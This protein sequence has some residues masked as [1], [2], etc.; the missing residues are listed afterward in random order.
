MEQNTALQPVETQHGREIVNIEDYAMSIDGLVGQVSLIQQVM[1]KVMKKDE[2]Y[3]VIPGTG[4]K[5]SLL[6]PGAEKLCLTFRL[7]P[8]YEIIREVR[9]RDFIAYTVKCTLTHIPT[10]Q[11]IA[12][13]IG[14][15]NSRE[16]KYRYRSDNTGREVP[17][18]YWKNRDPEIL[19]GPTCKPRK[20]DG[21]WVVF[22]QV[23]NDNPWDLDNTL[24]KMACKRALVA[25]TLNATAASDIFTQDIEDMP[26]ELIGGAENK[27][28]EASNGKAKG[29]AQGNGRKSQ[30]RTQKK[31]FKD[32]LAGV[33]KDFLQYFDEDAW[34]AAL[35]SMDLASDKA[36]EKADRAI[37]E[38]LYLS[39]INAIEKEKKAAEATQAEADQ[40]LDGI[41]DGEQ[42]QGSLPWDDHPT[43]EDPKTA[44]NE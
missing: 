1:D 37:Q 10:G 6:K 23:E 22:E 7:D 15:C 21:K 19:G 16:T 5:P 39:L 41:I 13:G 33:K 2:H 42:D 8:N 11:S 34:A 30:E 38:K 27:P 17:K 32:V 26:K 24:I 40:E 14:S 3:G 20:K 12:S 18:E 35:R 44:A 9:D 43:G 36:A 29:K 28:V 25:A 31:E 4:G